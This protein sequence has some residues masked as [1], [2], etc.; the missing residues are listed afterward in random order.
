MLQ[1]YPLFRI[2]KIIE[3]GVGGGVGAF[4]LQWI[5]ARINFG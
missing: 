5:F 4:L 2:L 3:M 1:Q